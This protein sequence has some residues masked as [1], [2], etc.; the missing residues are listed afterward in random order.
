MY[1]GKLQVAEPFVV[2]RVDI[3][4]TIKDLIVEALTRFG[5]DSQDVDD[6]R[7][8]EILL[9]RGGRKEKGETLNENENVV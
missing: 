3:A 9:D 6:Y 7:L 5:L 4:T 8:S 1:P 2:I